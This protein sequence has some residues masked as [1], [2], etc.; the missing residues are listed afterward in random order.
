[1]A[2]TIAGAPGSAAPS[3]DTAIVA[4]DVAAPKA[5]EPKASD[6]AAKD[7]PVKTLLSAAEDEK[8]APKADG[9]ATKEGDKGEPKNDGAPAEYKLVLP[10]KSTLG[11]EDVDRVTAFAREHGLSQDVAQAALNLSNAVVAQ[12]ES[13]Y[14]ESIKPGGAEWTERVK[15]WN[16][17]ALADKEIGGNTDN[18]KEAALATKK[19]I[20]TFFGE[21]AKPLLDFLEESGMAS[22]PMILKGFSRIAKRMSE[23]TISRD[24]EPL[25]PEKKP[26]AERLYNKTPQVEGVAK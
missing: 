14:N 9:D 12:R 11:T 6:A 24:A 7:E 20:N 15:A 3:A 1:M 25:V 21:D 8:P 16:A 10:E 19:A 23:G 13:A 2:D 17:A 5:D 22:H 26:M 18:V 4:S